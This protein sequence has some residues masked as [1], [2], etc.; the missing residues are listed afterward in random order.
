MSDW[1]DVYDLCIDVIVMKY[2][3]IM[4]MCVATTIHY[5]AITDKCVATTGLHVQG[6]IE[7]GGT[8]TPYLIESPPLEIMDQYCICL[9]SWICSFVP[10]LTQTS[11]APILPWDN[12]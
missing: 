9:C 5:V 8:I 10:C 12:S 2:D 11:F 4:S 7:G 3:A 6:F 1:T